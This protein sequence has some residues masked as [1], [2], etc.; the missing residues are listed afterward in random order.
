MKILST[1]SEIRN[2]FECFKVQNSKRFCLSVHFLSLFGTF[3]FWSFEIVSDF[4]IRISDFIL[5]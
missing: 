5:V 4:D 3:G 1:K 2:K